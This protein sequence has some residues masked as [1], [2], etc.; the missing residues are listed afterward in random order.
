MYVYKRMRKKWEHIMI[1]PVFLPGLQSWAVTMLL[2]FQNLSSSSGTSPTYKCQA[3]TVILYDSSQAHLRI[4]QLVGE[5]LSMIAEIYSSYLLSLCLA[6]AHWTLL[7]RHPIQAFC[8]LGFQVT[9]DFKYKIEHISNLSVSLLFRV[10]YGKISRGK[11]IHYFTSL[12]AEIL[13]NSLAV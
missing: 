7:L 1:Y 10:T 5:L 2:A 11:K 8:H 12:K 13:G 9:P 6:T 4:H 3:E